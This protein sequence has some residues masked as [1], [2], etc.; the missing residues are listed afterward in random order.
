MY[1]IN[2]FLKFIDALA[3]SPQHI[4][5]VAYYLLCTLF[6]YLVFQFQIDR[7]RYFFLDEPNPYEATE[8]KEIMQFQDTA[9]KVLVCFE[10]TTSRFR[11]G[12]RIPCT[13]HTLSNLLNKHVAMLS[14]NDLMSCPYFNV[15]RKHND[16]HTVEMLIKLRNNNLSVVCW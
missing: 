12:N 4:Y 14:I 13:T 2:H 3:F 7:F 9:T 15:Q 16:A 5:R 6:F 8:R 11:F 1:L 10:L